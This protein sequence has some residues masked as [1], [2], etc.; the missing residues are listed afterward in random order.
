MKKETTEQMLSRMARER[1]ENEAL[2]RGMTVP[3]F[4]AMQRACHHVWQNKGYYSECP[5]CDAVTG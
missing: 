1:E 2:K 4:R 3:Q 5:K